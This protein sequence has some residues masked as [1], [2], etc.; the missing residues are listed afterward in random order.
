MNGKIYGIPYNSV[1][2]LQIKLGLPTN[3]DWMLDSKFN[4][5]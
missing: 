4:K 5:F 3:P 2:L 1:N